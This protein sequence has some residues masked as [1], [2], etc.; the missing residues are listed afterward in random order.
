MDVDWK[1][2]DR[3][4]APLPPTEA[5]VPHDPDIDRRAWDTTA[6][7][8][9]ELGKKA[10]R[11]I[12]PALYAR[13]YR[14]DRA[15]LLAWK[16]KCGRRLAV[17]RR[18]DWPRR[19]LALELRVRQQV[20]QTLQERPPRRAS[21]SHVLGML[22]LRALVAH[23]AALLPRTSAVLDALCET[24]EAYQLRRLELVF[25]QEVGHSIPDWR[26]LR[27]A[28]IQAGRLPD[29]GQGLIQRARRRAKEVANSEFLP[30]AVP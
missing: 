27:D 9:S 18:I 5:A 23:R 15:W 4:L 20:A 2:A 3:L 8:H 11:R 14:N 28:R 22:G 26:A 29:G 19:D 17:T 13:L 6:A 1:T 24:V 10:L 7:A 21:R 25:S 16:A 30:E 12:A